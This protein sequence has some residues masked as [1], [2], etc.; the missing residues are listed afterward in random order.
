ML[1]RRKGEDCKRR[2]YSERWMSGL[3]MI[4]ER[5]M[6]EEGDDGRGR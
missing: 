1:T 5:E 4:G 2:R 3:E 6:M